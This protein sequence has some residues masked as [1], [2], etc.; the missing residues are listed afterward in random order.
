[1]IHPDTL[2]GHILFLQSKVHF[3]PDA[4][5]PDGTTT[6][7]NSLHRSSEVQTM[8]CTFIGAK[9]QPTNTFSPFY[10]SRCSTSAGAMTETG[11]SNVQTRSVFSNPSTAM[12]RSP[13][14][15]SPSLAGSN[16]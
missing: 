12:R 6:E 3:A 4:K 2:F 1:M 8:R 15:P 10:F 16:T 9:A 11:T 7:A 5:E 14:N 13:K